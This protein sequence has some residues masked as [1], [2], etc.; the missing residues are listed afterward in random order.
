MSA[1]SLSDA[2]RASAASSC[3]ARREPARQAAHARRS[4]GPQRSQAR[5]EVERA[6]RASERVATTRPRH[7]RSATS[8]TADHPRDAPTEDARPTAAAPPAEARPI[9]IAPSR[10]SFAAKPSTA[11]SMRAPT[12]ALSRASATTP[13]PTTA[14]GVLTTRSA[15]RCLRSRRTGGGRSSSSAPSPSAAKPGTSSPAATATGETATRAPPPRSADRRRRAGRSP[16]RS[17]TCSAVSRRG[18]SSPVEGTAGGLP[19][20]PGSFPAP[21]RPK[22]ENAAHSE[23]RD[24]GGT[25]TV[26][27]CCDSLPREACWPSRPSAC[28]PEREATGCSARD[29]LAAT[30]EQRAPSRM[31]PGLSRLTAQRGW[32]YGFGR[33]MSFCAI[34]SRSRLG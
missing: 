12:R 27:I 24:T 28:A 7:T 6:S 29:P 5:M 31:D 1:D 10:P 13:R 8:C 19:S 26:A 20:T 15:E 23:P 4:T 14:A 9:R 33:G 18:G 22:R 32:V 34:T 3:T 21:S 17:T 11:S 30:R 2:E 25:R 16:S